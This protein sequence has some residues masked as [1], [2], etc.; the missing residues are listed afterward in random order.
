MT[1]ATTEIIIE[2]IRAAEPLSP[3]A[4]FRCN[5]IGHLDAVFASTFETKRR[6]RQ[7]D[8]YYVGTFSKV[9]DMLDVAEILE[10]ESALLG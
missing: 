6:I 5:K 1:I 8:K 2:R 3:I 9:S 10:R 7:K 4:V